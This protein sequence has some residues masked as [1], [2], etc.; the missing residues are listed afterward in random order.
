MCVHAYNLTDIMST[1]LLLICPS[2]FYL[3]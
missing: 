2:L 1:D 3:G